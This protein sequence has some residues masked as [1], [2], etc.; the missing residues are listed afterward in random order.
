MVRNFN[1]A[2]KNPQNHISRRLQ[3]RSTAIAASRDKTSA[4]GFRT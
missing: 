3:G 2:E 1:D 4:G